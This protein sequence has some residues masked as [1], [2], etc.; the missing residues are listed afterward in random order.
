[1]TLFVSKEEF[2][3]GHAG[4]TKWDRMMA[5]IDNGGAIKEGMA[6]SVGDSLTYWRGTAAAFADEAFVGHRRYQTVFVGLEGEVH[7][8]VA[9][10]P[11]FVSAEAY[12]DLSDRES[13][14][15]TTPRAV[16]TWEVSPGQILVVP[17]DHAWRIVTQPDAH[18][19]TV[20][21][22]VEGATFHNK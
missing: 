5:A 18:L 13:F 9:P 20:R 2:A 7:I 15:G 12:S 8:E 19:L 1:M 21:I 17:I 14:L 10:Q 3:T 4:V 22:T 16:T 11:E 6:H